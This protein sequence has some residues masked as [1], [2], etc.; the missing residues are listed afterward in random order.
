MNTCLIL[1]AGAS[2]SNAMHFHAERLRRTWPPLDTTFFENVDARGIA[3]SPG[4]RRYLQEFVGINPTTSTLR[5]FRMEEIFKDASYDF[6]ETPGNKVAL[7]AY[8]DLVD[9]YLRILRETTNWL[10]APKRRGGPIGRLLDVAAKGAETLTVITFNHDLVIE[11]E[12]DRRARL[13]GRWCLDHGYGSV[14]EELSVL[15]P[16]NSS[17]P[18]FRLHD[19][20]GCEH[21]APITLLKLHG[22]LNWV[23]RINGKRP[24][25]RFLETGGGKGKLHLSTRK[26]ISGR[27]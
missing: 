10:C 19:E 6:R 8:I 20:G 24:T 1:G 12:I 11:N 14:S 16:T 23:M 2:L 9:L 25:A 21:Q 15:N 5:E 17:E 13:R 22:S 7:D 4:I 27:G 26:Q 3:L 18:V